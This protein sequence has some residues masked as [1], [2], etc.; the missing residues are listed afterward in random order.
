[1]D[2]ATPLNNGGTVG[3]ALAVKGGVVN[4]RKLDVVA[5][6]DDA[7]AVKGSAVVKGDTVYSM[8][9]RLH[10]RWRTL[11]HAFASYNDTEVLPNLLA[12]RKILRTRTHAVLSST[13]GV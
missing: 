2:L 8:C 6:T 13:P 12:N 7:L 9:L 3:G 1:M 5:I 4:G 11:Q 10:N